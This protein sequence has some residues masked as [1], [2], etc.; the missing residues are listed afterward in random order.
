MKCQVEQQAETRQ[1]IMSEVLVALTEDNPASSC[2]SIP[3]SRLWL[4]LDIPYHWLNCASVLWLQPGGVR[5]V[6]SCSLLQPVRAKPAGNW[7]L[8]E[9]IHES[10]LI[11]A[12]GRGSGGCDSTFFPTF[13]LTYNRVYGRILAYQHSNTHAFNQLIHGS[14][15][16]DPYLDGVSLTHGSVG[17]RQHI[18]S[19]ASSLSDAEPLPGQA[20]RTNYV[21][22]CTTL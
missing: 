14:T 4:L 10:R 15:I 1:Q 13:G 22:S 12:C 2:T 3:V 6:D 17:S 7:F 20:I 9:S 21:C 18:W 11:R 5:C 19:F 16:D 8:N